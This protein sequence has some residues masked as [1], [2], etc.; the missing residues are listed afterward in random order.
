MDMK[1]KKFT[2]AKV[3]AWCMTLLSLLMTEGNAETLQYRH[4]LFFKARFESAN[5]T[6]ADWKTIWTH[7]GYALWKD[8]AKFSDRRPVIY[9]Q[10]LAGEKKGKKRNIDG[11]E[12]LMM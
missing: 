6:A 8:T 4:L 2:V 7:N 10:P 11:G 5:V 12:L 1:K 3:T 9:A